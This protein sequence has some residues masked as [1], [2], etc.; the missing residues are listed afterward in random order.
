VAAIFDTL[1]YLFCSRAIFGRD[2]YT[3]Q[4]GN[5]VKYSSADLLSFYL[6]FFVKVAKYGN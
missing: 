1:I 5:N 3:A 2:F 6:G 4:L